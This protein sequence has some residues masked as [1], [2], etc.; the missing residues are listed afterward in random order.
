MKTTRTFLRHYETT[1]SPNNALVLNELLRNLE[2]SYHD[3]P[4]Q[5]QVLQEA[6]NGLAAHQKIQ[7]MEIEM[8]GAHAFTDASA[9]NRFISLAKEVAKT[10]DPKTAAKF[11]KDITQVEIEW[12][13]TIR[14][15]TTHGS[16]DRQA[17]RDKHQELRTMQETLLRILQGKAH[18]PRTWSHPSTE[19]DHESIAT[20]SHP[21]ARKATK[22]D[23]EVK[24][25]KE[26]VSR[27]SIAQLARNGD[28]S[29][30]DRHL[31]KMA[32]PAKTKFMHFEMQGGHSFMTFAA[33]Q[34]DTDV[35]HTLLKHGMDPTHT[36]SDG[37]TPIQAAQ[38][39]GHHEVALLLHRHIQAQKPTTTATPD[40]GI[41]LREVPR[42]EAFAAAK[43]MPV[44][45]HNPAL[46]VTPER[47]PAFQ[48][49]TTISH[50]SP[51]NN[52]SPHP[53]PT[54][55]EHALHHRTALHVGPT[56]VQPV[57]SAW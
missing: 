25:T 6:A 10:K 19:D 55:Q 3:S 7:L 32:E 23:V 13:N 41:A 27:S 22:Q 49:G 4:V 57:E 29:T 40:T 47:R 45:S 14:F 53:G 38:A 33:A 30:L 54:L 52:R 24:P 1:L 50:R 21:V 5:V 28:A 9:R 34:G 12:T 20:T 26:S 15:I 48:P 37:V 56:D 11:D 39:N 36:G 43:T 46:T 2:R 18:L 51:L 44:P 17:I 42:K 31:R 8:N 16:G 35:V